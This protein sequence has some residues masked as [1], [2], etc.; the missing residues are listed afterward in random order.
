MTIVKHDKCMIIIG[1]APTIACCPTRF[2]RRRRVALPQQT[3]HIQYLVAILK[4][5][6]I[7]ICKFRSD[8]FFKQRRSDSDYPNTVKAVAEWLTS[9]GKVTRKNIADVRNIRAGTIGDHLKEMVEKGLLDKPRG[10][11]YYLSPNQMIVNGELRG[12][13]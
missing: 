8:L 9:R 12:K 2:A 1:I 5:P 7:M 10:H 13:R 11:S 4:I 3:D 6:K